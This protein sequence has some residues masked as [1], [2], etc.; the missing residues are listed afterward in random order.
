MSVQGTDGVRRPRR[1]YVSLRAPCLDQFAEIWVVFDEFG[2]ASLIS[3]VPDETTLGPPDAHVE[4]TSL[5]ES[6]VIGE[7]ST[8]I[9]TL[10]NLGEGT[11]D[12]MIPGAELVTNTPQQAQY[13]ELGKNE[14]DTRTGSP[15]VQGSGGPDGFG[16]RWT[17]SDSPFG[18]TRCRMI[19][20]CESCRNPFEHLK[21]V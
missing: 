18:P 5:T 1:D 17:D 4:P 8:R 7:T 3:N 6:L 21:K 14:T 2:N 19:Y 15:V 10:S 9:L 11:L 20:Y 12:F 16:Y 13:T